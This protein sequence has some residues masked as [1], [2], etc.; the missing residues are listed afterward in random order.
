MTTAR[1]KAGKLILDMEARRD[2]KG[3]L[4]VY[5]LPK[6]DGGG[7]YEVAGINEKYHPAM[8][9]KLADLINAKQ[10]AEAEA[11]A[12]EFICK[13]TDATG[14]QFRDPGVSYLMRDIAFN[15][16]PGGANCIVR[17]ALGVPFQK[18]RL[19][20]LW[21]PLSQA[22]RDEMNA[23]PPNEAIEKITQ[24]RQDYEYAYA[25]LRPNLDRGLRNRWANARKA[26][27]ALSNQ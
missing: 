19:R 1:L 18:S 16:G 7:S 25:G 5:R 26:A 20:A 13:Y 4:A 21:S 11:E 23:L 15:R 17:M 14:N 12:I 6:N 9:K 2:R 3:N 10:F 24:A 27:L 8:A 22:F